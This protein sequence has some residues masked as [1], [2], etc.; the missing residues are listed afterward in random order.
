MTRR[1]SRTENAQLVS[2]HQQPNRT[3]SA[4]SSVPPEN[5]AN[6]P[7]QDVELNNVDE[8]HLVRGYD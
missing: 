7:R 5:G 8:S 6:A 1:E 2:P 4:P 3:P